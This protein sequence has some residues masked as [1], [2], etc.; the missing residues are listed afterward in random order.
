M[1]SSSHVVL[2]SIAKKDNNICKSDFSHPMKS[3]NYRQGQIQ[4]YVQSPRCKVETPNLNQYL[5][6][7]FPHNTMENYSLMKSSMLGNHSQI[8]QTPTNT[9]YF[10][11]I[12]KSMLNSTLKV[13]PQATMKIPRKGTEMMQI[14]ELQTSKDFN[15]NVDF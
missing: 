15:N 9:N 2:S 13:N 7:D 3:T 11:G 8:Q 6:T 1:K 14:Q 12:R 10:S 4:Q 5:H